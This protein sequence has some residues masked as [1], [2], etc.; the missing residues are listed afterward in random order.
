MTT[1]QVLLILGPTASGKSS[2]AMAL[3]QQIDPQPQIVSADSM[4]IYRGMDIGTAKPSVADRAAVAHHMIDVASPYEAGFSL[5]N[6]LIGCR[7]AIAQINA[8]G[9]LAIVVGGTNLYVQALIEGIFEGPAANLKLRDELGAVSLREIHERLLRVDPASAARIHPNDRR[10]MIR[11]IEVTEA[12]GTPL[13]TLQTQWHVGPPTLPQGW[14]CAGFMPDPPTNS[15]S[16]NRRVKVM[17]EGGFVEEV[18]QLRAGGSLGRQAA[19]AV[20]YRELAEYLDGNSSLDSATESIK[21][22]TRKLARQQRT[23]LRRFRHIDRSNWSEGL[24]DPPEAAEFLKMVLGR[25]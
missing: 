8:L 9:K 2:F 16:I 17:I 24:N 3:A 21:I 12:T 15:R 14:S 4:Q 1:P 13:S 11:A 19:E 18:R 7:A 10:R 5:E 23:W 6:W 20:G 25:L 22:R